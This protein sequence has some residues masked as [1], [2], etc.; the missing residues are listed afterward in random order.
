MPARGL[1]QAQKRDEDSVRQGSFCY[2]TCSM[3]QE[4]QQQQQQQARCILLA[5]VW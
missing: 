2:D 5:P 3:C 1:A 4:L